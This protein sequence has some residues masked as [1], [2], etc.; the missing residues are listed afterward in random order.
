[1]R[2]A[3]RLMAL[4]AE[5]VATPR[6]AVVAAMAASCCVAHL[7]AGEGCLAVPLGAVA[8][9]PQGLTAFWWGTILVTVQIVKILLE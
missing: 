5:P 1:M 7:G 8:D 2:A 6:R 4:A 3:P 9:R